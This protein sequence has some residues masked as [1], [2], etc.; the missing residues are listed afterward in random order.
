MIFVDLLLFY[1]E[2]LKKIE[3]NYDVVLKFKIVF[4]L[5]LGLCRLGRPNH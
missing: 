2:N 5:S 3:L 4:F 1:H